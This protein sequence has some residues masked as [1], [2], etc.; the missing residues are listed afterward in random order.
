MHS[1]I[2][3]FTENPLGTLIGPLTVVVGFGALWFGLRR[4]GRSFF[5][6]A[7]LL[8]AALCWVVLTLV[9][10]GR[11]SQRVAFPISFAAAVL[12]WI[13]FNALGLLIKRF[14]RPT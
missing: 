14:R 13:L 8:A 7:A 11:Y 6:I 5:D 4:K 2:D 9:L 1:W 3:A 12:C 10:K